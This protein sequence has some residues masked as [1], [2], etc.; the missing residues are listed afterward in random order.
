MLHNISI[1]IVVE[2]HSIDNG[3]YA[4]L[5]KLIYEQQLNIKLL[6]KAIPNN[7]IE[8]YGNHEQLLELFE[9]DEKS[10]YQFCYGVVSNYYE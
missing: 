6:S 9:L 1:A 4:Q 2:E 7:F 3:L 8:R 5:V 10:I